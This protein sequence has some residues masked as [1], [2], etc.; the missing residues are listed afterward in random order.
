M[1][2]RFRLLNEQSQY[3][4]LTRE[5]PSN[6]SLA[7]LNTQV[8]VSDGTVSVKWYRKPSPKN[9]L[10]HAKSAHPA[11]LKRAVV[12]N[13]FRKATRMCTGMN[14]YRESLLLASDIA[15]SNG[16]VASTRHRRALSEMKGRIAPT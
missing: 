13:M 1:E 2:E 3:I 11:A 4:R 10:I 16:Y 9:I 7:Y 15:V 6:G 12:S 8:R 14:E 5:T